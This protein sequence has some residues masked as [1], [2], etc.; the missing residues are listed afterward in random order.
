MSGKLVMALIA[1]SVALAAGGAWAFAPGGRYV[2][3]T[4]TTLDTKT[5]LL[6]QR[7]PSTIKY[8]HRSDA[9]VVC[10]GLILDGLSGWRM[11]ERLELETLVDVR[12]ANPAIDTN[13][14]PDTPSDKFWTA[15]DSCWPNL[16]WIVHFGAGSSV[17]G[18][19]DVNPCYVRCVR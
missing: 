7:N 19:E 13:A 10:Q 18:G 6:W 4:Y 1:A 17:Y 9:A 14:F 8:V 3:G 2:T 16:A 15:T 11:P 12:A 5:G